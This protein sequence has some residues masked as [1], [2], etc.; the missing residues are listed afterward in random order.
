MALQI[1]N[2]RIAWLQSLRPGKS[3]VRITVRKTGTILYG[4]YK[5][6]SDSTI[7]IEST[8]STIDHLFRGGIL[9][10]SQMDLRSEDMTFNF[11]DIQMENG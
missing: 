11:L 7:T 5:S 2:R 9:V 6:H 1:V 10:L 4:I 8:R 3:V